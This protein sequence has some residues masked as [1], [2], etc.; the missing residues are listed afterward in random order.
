M[1]ISPE[2]IILKFDVNIIKKRVFLICGNE[3][4]LINKVKDEL[5]TKYKDIG[6]DYI[7]NDPN[8]NLT[9]VGNDRFE[10][11]LFTQL[12]IIVFENPSKVEVSY[13]NKIDL[14]NNVI[15][16]LHNKLTNISKIK[17]TFEAHK[18]FVAINC[19]KLTRDI[20]KVYFDSFLS[21]NKITLS[22]DVY[23]HI[24]DNTSDYYQ[25]FENEIKKLIHYNKNKITIKEVKFLLST[26]VQNDMDKIFF[27][28]LG[29]FSNIIT[30][31]E[32]NILSSS[33]SYFLLQRIKFFINLLSTSKNIEEA[34]K[35]FPKYLFK[36]K[37]NYLKIF[38]KSNKNKF[39]L[40]I[41]LIS[42]AE[43][44]LRRYQ[45][46]HLLIMQRFLINLKKTLV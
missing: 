12:Q 37:S 28:I 21:L 40:A 10:Q 25:L 26:F 20:K 18:D 8:K 6:F 16:I 13:F 45:K 24:I 44:M 17:K 46:N 31:T 33:D 3:E 23:W 14:V 27:L 42:K 32:K 30:Q 15:I 5:I 22:A 41:S 34:E 35:K 38:K 2:K 4:T 39:L 19:Y 43:L 11:Q 9:E 7:K 1:K 36:E 29:G